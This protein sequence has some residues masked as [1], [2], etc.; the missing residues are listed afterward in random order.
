MDPR[1][2]LG[3]RELALRFLRLA[4]SFR[5]VSRIHAGG[6]CCINELVGRCRSLGTALS[7][8]P[9]LMAINLEELSQL[10][11]T[12]PQFSSALGYSLRGCHHLCCVL[13]QEME[14]ITKETQ[15]ARVDQLWRDDA[16]KEVAL[17][18]KAQ[19][20]VLKILTP[21]LES[22][23]PMTISGVALSDTPQIVLD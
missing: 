6:K 13:E 16:V 20:A 5:E 10:L 21:I 11:K 12:Q 18:T 19:E 9:H 2:A 1:I 3:A 8:L 17:H 14:L 23:V 22:S 7:G 15:E 4:Q